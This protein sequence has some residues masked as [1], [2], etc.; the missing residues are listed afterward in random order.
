[1]H[2]CAA[3]L[4]FLI[5][6]VLMVTISDGWGKSG[7]GTQVPMSHRV[8]RGLATG[9]FRASTGGAAISRDEFSKPRQMMGCQ[10]GHSALILVHQYVLH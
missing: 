8:R 7:V 5:S 3:A 6:W 10:A 9:F 2:V 1:M 4:S